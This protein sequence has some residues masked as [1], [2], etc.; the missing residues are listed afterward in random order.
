MSMGQMIED[1]KLACECKLP[2]HFHG[3]PGGMVPLPKDLTRL[4]KEILSGGAK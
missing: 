2:V 4:A 3:R 1:V